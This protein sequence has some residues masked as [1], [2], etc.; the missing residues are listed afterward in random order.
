MDAS[1]Q[2]TILRAIVIS[3]SATYSSGGGGQQQQ[4]QQPISQQDRL[5]AFQVL[6][7]FKRYDGRIPVALTWLQQERHFHQQQQQLFG[8]TTGSST[9]SSNSSDNN[10]LLDITIQTK[11]FALEIV[12]ELLQT[13][14]GKL[15]HEERLA[16]RR[17]VLTA[18][19]QQ[20]P[21]S[22]RRG[23]GSRIL[24]NKIA[25]LL[26]GLVVR[27]F[28]QRWT[29]LMDDVFVP[30]QQGGLWYNTEEDMDGLGVKICLECLKLVAEDCTDSDFNAKVCA[31]QQK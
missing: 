29:T 28:P 19:R 12:H 8:T 7:D 10:N 17:A 9:S 13:S 14:Y 31:I 3:S 16:V 11:L 4:Q 25:L 15:S 1:Q 5:R 22:S 26:A 21:I 30:I 2:E 23:D 24:A 20:A 18:A 27:D 6:T